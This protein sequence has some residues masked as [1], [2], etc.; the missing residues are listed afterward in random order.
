MLDALLLDFLRALDE[1]TWLSPTIAGNWTIKDIAAHLLD[2]NLRG[3]SVSRDG[4][5]IAPGENVETYPNL[6]AYLNRLNNEW[7]LA[8]KRLSPA[9][10]I[11]LLAYTG[12][13]Y[14]SHLSK[15]DPET[16]AVFGVAWAGEAL[17]SNR[18]HLAREFTEKFLH[19]QQIRDALGD[20][21]LLH[22][23]LFH[24][25]IDTCMFALP[26]AYKGFPG[27]EGTVIEIEVFGKVGGKWQLVRQDKSWTLYR[28]A[29]HDP[30]TSI[31]L[32]T[33]IAWKLFSKGIKSEQTLA[34]VQVE[35]IQALAVPALSAA[36]FM[37]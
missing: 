10:L 32:D 3:L 8:T 25:F 12:S 1:K 16:Q 19:Q 9:V 18:M 5:S 29:G 11:E 33:D 28:G 13:L 2:G 35:G 31:R 4:F 26:F 34:F 15:L 27:L 30:N 22:H 20:Q 37:A 23:A 24:P 17:S 21:S 14:S 7:T 6:L 36:A